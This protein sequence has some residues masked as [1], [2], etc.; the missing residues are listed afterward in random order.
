MWED[1]TLSAPERALAFVYARYAGRNDYSW[2]TWD[3]LIKRSGIR[4]RATIGKH[5][6]SLQAK[7][8]LTE[9]EPPR[10][11]YSARYLLTDPTAQQF[12][13]CTAGDQ[14]TESPVVQFLTSS[15]SIPVPEYSDTE[16]REKNG[17]TLPPDPLRPEHA[18]RTR[19]EQ[20]DPLTAVPNPNATND[21]TS[22]PRA[23]AIDRPLVALIEGE[24]PVH[25]IDDYQLTLSVEIPAPQP[26][27][28]DDRRESEWAA[29]AP[30]ITRLT[31]PPETV[32]A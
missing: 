17:G 13:N 14:L 5:L 16:V 3:E 6:A 1:A 7:G 12:K 27:A 26:F 24:P 30:H 9:K 19:T 25:Q 10:Q 32:T 4:S 15:S 23:H 21:V 29:I 31:K 2:C 28:P 8:W 22:R 20:H 11:H 18:S